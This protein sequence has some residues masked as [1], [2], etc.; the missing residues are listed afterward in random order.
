MTC[1]PQ[2]GLESK[3]GHLDLGEGCYSCQECQTGLLVPGLEWW[4]V[5][6]VG[7]VGGS[8]QT[9]TSIYFAP[10]TEY[11]LYKLPATP[12]QDLDVWL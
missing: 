5:W 2:P 4:E 9:Y 7:Q 10:E 12:E 1:L 3:C 11:I 6:G 8:N